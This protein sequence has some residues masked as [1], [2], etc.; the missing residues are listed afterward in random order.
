M[1]AFQLSFTESGDPDV[2]VDAEDVD[3]VAPVEV[4]GVDV[5]EP[6][7]EVAAVGLEP[8]PETAS[9]T[10]DERLELL[11]VIPDDAAPVAEG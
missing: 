4:E 7:A 8:D 5:V 10:G 11:M 2:G 1:L 3:E 6:E 9:L